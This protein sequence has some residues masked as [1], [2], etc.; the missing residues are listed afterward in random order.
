[1]DTQYQFSIKTLLSKYFPHPWDTHYQFSIKTLLSKEERL[2]GNPMNNPETQTKNQ[3][4]KTTE[5]LRHSDKVTRR[6]GRTPTRQASLMEKLKVRI[7][8]DPAK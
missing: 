8:D 3:K 4:P 2:L 7:S 6:Y 5:T 1:M